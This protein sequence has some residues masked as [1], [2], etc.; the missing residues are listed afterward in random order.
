MKIKSFKIHEKYDHHLYLNDIALVELSCKVNFKN[1]NIA[2][3]CLPSK[4]ISIYP[5]EE[6]T[7]TVAGWGSLEENGS[8]SNVLRQVHLTVLSNKNQFCIQQISDEITQFCA[9][10]NQGGKDACQGDR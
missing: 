4:N 5:Y 3:I 7:G 6:T 8:I 10:S 9:G 2:T 1:T